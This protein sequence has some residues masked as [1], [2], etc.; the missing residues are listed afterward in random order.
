MTVL[1]NGDIIINENAMENEN[2]Q[3]NENLELIIQEIENNDYDYY[4]IQLMNDF[5][6]FYNY[7][8]IMNQM[9]DIIIFLVK[10]PYLLYFYVLMGDLLNNTL[11]N[12]LLFKLFIEKNI[13][14]LLKFY[15]VNN[16][17]ENIYL[18]S[19]TKFLLINNINKLNKEIFEEIFRQN[20]CELNDDSSILI[21]YKYENK[22]YRLYINYK[23]IQ[24]NSYEFPL[25]I[26]QIQENLEKKYNR[27]TILFFKNEC[28][29]IKEARIN[30]IDIKEIIE[31][32][33]GPF[34]DFGLIHNH[35]VY[36]KHLV[37][38][39]GIRLD[40]FR[41][42]EIKYTNFYMDEIDM[43][44]IDHIIHITNINDYIQS[45][46]INNKLN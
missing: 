30:D 33:N 3:N 34:Y 37:K 26:E 9:Y 27:N 11:D 22:N 36:I 42:L 28:N 14:E 24:N 41:E 5:V 43:V 21:K 35:K 25:N 7:D 29:E 6:N 16:Q 44:L 23:D 2:I 13:N 31:E 8:K 17:I 18:I 10:H 12:I 15:I 32:C 40:E 38:E 45:E 1:I 19:D 4:T 20:N 39:L 46:I